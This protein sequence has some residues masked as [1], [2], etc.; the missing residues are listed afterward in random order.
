MP[1]PS[2]PQP[3]PQST[4]SP[5]PRPPPADPDLAGFLLVD[6]PSGCTSHDVVVSIRRRFRVKKVGHG[7]TL[8]PM[9]TG[10]L[11]LLIGRATKL[12][13]R[14]MGHDKTYTATMRLGIETDSQDAEGTPVATAAPEAVAAIGADDLR[15]AFAD[16]TGDIYQTPPMA[17][18]KKIDGVPL[19]KLARQGKVVPREPRIIHVYRFD[20]HRYTPPDADF[21]VACTKG[22]YIR[23]LAHDAGQA[24]HVGA[25][26]IRLRRT[27]LGPFAVENSIPLATLLAA[28]SLAPYLLPL[29]TPLD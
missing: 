9:A 4:P 14:V 6:K 18:A 17:S 21:T 8:D 29:T 11:V 15:R 5:C 1:A 13:D 12:S 26:L 19:Y 24:L 16:L 10:L 22:T 2:L 25:H 28:D 27:K 3:S 20:L 7:G 23:T